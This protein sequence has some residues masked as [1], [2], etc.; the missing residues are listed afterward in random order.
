MAFSGIYRRIGGHFRHRRHSW[1][2]REFQ[3]CQTVVDLG[4]TFESWNEQGF[5]HITLVNV[6]PFRG[7]PPPGFSYLQADGCDSHLPG[8]F[9]LAF[10][11]S[12]IEHLGTLERQQ[13]FASEMLRLGRRFYCQAPNRWFP[14]E[15][16]YLGI[17]LHWLPPSFFSHFLH[18]WC[19]LQGLAGRPSRSESH[20]IRQRESIR[21]LSKRELLEMFPGCNLRTERFLGWPKSFIVWR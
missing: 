16:H 17:F 13:R 11:N 12:V 9:D 1:L 7:N 8:G 2:T 18:R 4:G 5:P 14:V 3:D 10:S 6:R 19:T 20:A 15:P 21:W